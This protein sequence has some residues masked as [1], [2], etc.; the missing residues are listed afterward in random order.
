MGGVWER[1]VGLARKVLDDILMG[2]GGKALMAE[3]MAI[4]NSRP[5]SPELSYPDMPLVLSPAMLLNQKIS[6]HYATC[7]SVDVCDIHKE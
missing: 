7:V 1:M 3:E 6:E 2:N 4:S 5:I